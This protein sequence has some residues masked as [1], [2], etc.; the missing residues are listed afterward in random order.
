MNEKEKEANIEELVETQ[1]DR[2][3]DIT[4]ELIISVDFW[5]W[6]MSA[7]DVR[8]TSLTPTAALIWDKVNKVYF[9]G[10]NPFF[11]HLLS[12]EQ[13][14]TILQHELVHR[15]M[16]HHIRERNLVAAYDWIP[17]KILHEL[18]NIAADVAVHEVLD[19]SALRPYALEAELLGLPKNL[20][21]E[22]YVALIV[23]GYEEVKQE[24]EQMMAGQSQESQDGQQE[25]SQQD[26]QGGGQNDQQEDSQE[27]SQQDGQGGSQGDQQE[28]NQTGDQQSEQNDGQ[29]NSQENS[30]E[31]GQQSGQG[32]GQ[33]DQQEGNQENGQQSGQSGGQGDQQESSQGNSQQ[34]GQ[35]G[36]QNDQQGDQ[37]SQQEQGSQKSPLKELIRKMLEKA[38]AEEELEEGLTEEF[39]RDLSDLIKKT[40]KEHHKRFAEEI[41]EEEPQRWVM[42]RLVDQAIQDIKK[43]KGYLPGNIAEVV[44]RLPVRK[45]P[46]E[47]YFKSIV[48]RNL[49]GMRMRNWGRPNRRGYKYLPGRK[50]MSMPRLIAFCVDTSG[51]M[52]TEELA[53]ALGVLLDIKKRFADVKLVLVEGDTQITE[54]TA[55]INPREM[56]FK[57]RGGT[58]LTAFFELEKTLKPEITVIFTDGYD[59]LDS[60]VPPQKTKVVFLL[61]TNDSPV[62]EW[63]R[64]HNIA[65]VHVM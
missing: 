27:N 38:K 33:D 29:G 3:G 21:F 30:Q 13:L 34:N 11:T 60:A 45:L 35:G 20:S 19:A 50:P 28:S 46:W 10:V 26:G 62:E 57:G 32:G 64:K 16:E 48:S 41:G 5:G 4:K 37:G 63:A 44:K 25:N 42:R 40:L 6:V 36:G 2:I 12:D 47:K 9:I 8:Q 51:S 15:A 58:D 1:L 17:E 22:E 54:I 7:L 52:G 53:K 56:E 55:K 24:M 23:E 43:Q 18:M 65:I 61:T 31:N 59:Y 49:G 39:G 14:K